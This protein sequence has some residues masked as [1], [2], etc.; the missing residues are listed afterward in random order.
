MLVNKIVYI[1][2]D[3]VFTGFSDL[4]DVVHKHKPME[5][6]L[7]KTVSSVGMCPILWL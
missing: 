5:Q 6:P 4:R 1:S 2:A 3:I 7:G